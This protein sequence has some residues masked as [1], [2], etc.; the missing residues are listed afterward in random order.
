MTIYNPTL[1]SELLALQDEAITSELMGPTTEFI[2]SA[3]R[4]AD[5]LRAADEE[6]AR[7]RF[8]VQRMKARVEVARAGFQ[9][10]DGGY[11]DSLQMAIDDAEQALAPTPEEVK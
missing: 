6:V 11:G 10:A 7:L 2:H 3:H 1:T 4:L 8:T 5:Q 9:I